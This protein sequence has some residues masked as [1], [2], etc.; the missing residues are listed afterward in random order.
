MRR[1]PSVLVAVTFLILALLPAAAGV[2][3]PSTD[4]RR[5][6][7]FMQPLAT[8]SASLRPASSEGAA[9]QSDI[10]MITVVGVG[11]IGLAAMVRR[12]TGT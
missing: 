3:V 12:T 7:A 5:H 9:A 11:L 8:V 2:W 10:W 6:S 1:T 4:L